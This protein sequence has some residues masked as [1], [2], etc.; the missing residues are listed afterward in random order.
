MKGALAAMAEAAVSYVGSHPA[1]AGTLALLVTSDEEGPAIDG[2]SRV[3]GA[4]REQGIS[5]TGAIIGEPSS[6][7]HAG[8]AI[9]VGRRGS[10]GGQIRIEGTAGHVGYVAPEHNA[11]HQLVHFL[12]RCMAVGAGRED[13]LFPPLSFHVTAIEATSIGRNVVPAEAR[14][15]FNLRYP[16]ALTGQ[17]LEHEIEA[18]AREIPAPHELHWRRSAD[19]YLSFHG[20]LRTATCTVLERRLGQ[21]PE[22]RVDGGTSDG[23]FL[24]A[25]GCEVVELGLPSERLHAFD[26]RAAL[27]DLLTL[28]DVYREIVMHY[29]EGGAS[30]A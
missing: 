27:S 19:P 21:P 15:S 3:L 13:G 23:R 24:A 2:T 12:T 6:R 29:L 30:G 10:L 16:P 28:S 9:R 11:V 17:K 1:H 22:L 5:L 8:D 18:L 14:A 7:L 20:R 26:E 4:L 25:F